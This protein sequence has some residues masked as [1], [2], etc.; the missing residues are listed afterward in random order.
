LVNKNPT[1]DTSSVSHQ[2]LSIF[3]LKARGRE[4]H[5]RKIKPRR[6]WRALFGVKR[7]RVLKMM[8]P[9]V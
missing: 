1:R 7:L 8:R 9:K 3:F 5:A 4:R 2:Y 6:W